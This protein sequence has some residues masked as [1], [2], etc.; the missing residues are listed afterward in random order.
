MSEKQQELLMEEIGTLE[1]DVP[2]MPG[3]FH[4]R[5]VSAVKT[6]AEKKTSLPWKRVATTW[7][8]AAATMVF[9]LGG[10]VL[11][12]QAMDAAPEAAGL[13]TRAAEEYEE[14]GDYDMD[15]L[16]VGNG[17]NTMMYDVSYTAAAPR[18]A[19]ES[20]A[21]GAA[22]KEQKIIRSAYMTIA[23]RDFDASLNGLRQKCESLGG[24]VTSS[25]EYEENSGLRQAYLTMQI[26]SEKLDEFL[27]STGNMGRITQ[28]GESAYDAT[29]GYYDTLARLE[30]QQALMER[31]QSLVTETA[32]LSELLE[33]E[34]QIAD[35]QYTI[36]RLQESL[37]STDRQVDY[38][39]VD[40]TLREEKA[41]E[42]VEDGQVPLTQRL[43][44]ALE[45]GWEAFADFVEEAVLFVVAALPFV[46]IA[47]AAWLVAWVIIRRVKKKSK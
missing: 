29:E 40:V 32:S 26:P 20:A 6:D 5:W 24:M 28:K 13:K 34:T 8:A 46:G 15:G 31:L 16:M 41:S 18:A 35:T 10:A 22:V 37:Q 42:A 19:K 12:R 38:S 9:V 17:A 1:K 43:M 11:G 33:L 14:Y 39:T 4:E 3:D 27:Q 45:S 44:L 36:D 30:T 23:T 2:P 47:A 7:L 25:S 21:T